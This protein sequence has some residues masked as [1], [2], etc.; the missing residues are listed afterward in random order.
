MSIKKQFGFSLVELTIVI[1][2]IAILFTIAIVVYP[3]VQR[4]AR[5]AARVSAASQVMKLLQSYYGKY[6]NWPADLTYDNNMCGTQSGACSNWWDGGVVG[7]SN[8]ALMTELKKVGNPPAS[9][10]TL[11]QT[12]RYGITIGSTATTGIYFNNQF[13]PVFIFY[14]LEGAHVNCKLG[15]SIAVYASGSGP[16]YYV[17]STTGYSDDWVAGSSTATACMA[18]VQV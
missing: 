2:V 7:N 10:A 4:D 18:F 17:K 5:N 16:W 12:P 11:N 13:Q 14:W 6:G 9:I 1:I 8:S 3:N 15:N